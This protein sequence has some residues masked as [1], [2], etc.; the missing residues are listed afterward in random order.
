M[1]LVID[2]QGAQGAN[3]HLGIGRYS[4]ALAEA[5][6]RNAGGHEVWIALNA[7]FRDTIEDI[8]AALDGLVPQEQIVVWET[9]TPVAG[10]D[11]TNDWRRRSGE[12]LRESFL[13]SLKPDIVQVSS[14]FEGL[15][16][17]AVTSA[18]TFVDG[19]TTAITLYDL[20]PLIH[21]HAHLVNPA[22]E[23]W[24]L[25]KLASMRRAGLW[26]AI[27]NSSRREACD[28]LNLPP[29]K[30]VNISAAADARFRPIRLNR[31][32]IEAL[33]QRYGLTRPFVM[34]TGGNDHRKNIDGLINA[35]ARLPVAVRR[36]H[37]LA[38]VCS[39]Q[40][41]SIGS[42]M[43]YAKRQGLSTGEVIVT[44][45]VPDDDLVS[46]YNLCA[47]FCFPSRHEGFGLPGFGSYAVRRTYN[48]GEYVE[49]HGHH[50]AV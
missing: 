18:G 47:A 42:L 24:Y 3:R 10:I 8:R 48:R 40:E 1:K 9:P 4:L 17:D 11:S 30:V 19:R 43:G 36:A 39:E 12:V 26:L 31:A 50:W 46:L 7:T 33:R 25:R 32:A 2:L 34:Y 37:Q 29:D 27:S 23:R 5:M 14:L 6:A 28:W 35:Y 21:N 44:G 41:G 45:F 38:L 15:I 22:V 20:I 16:D 13:A 49:H